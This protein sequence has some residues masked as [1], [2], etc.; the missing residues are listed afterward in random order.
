MPKKDYLVQLIRSLNAAER[1]HF[2]SSV[3]DSRSDRQYLK[4]FHMLEGEQNYDAKTLCKK[5]N[6]QPKQLADDKYYLD[7]MLLKSLRSFDDPDWKHTRL[8]KDLQDAKILADHGMHDDALVAVDK[9]IKEA[10]YLEHYGFVL[11]A[12][13]L[14]RVCLWALLRYD[15]VKATEAERRQ[16]VAAYEEASDLWELSSANYSMINAGGKNAELKEMLKHPVLK[17]KAEGL[18]SIQAKSH[19]YD[20]HKRTY[21]QLNDMQNLRKT[22]DAFREFLTLHPA[23]RDIHAS[24][25]ISMRIN[26]AVQDCMHANY[27]RALSM[28]VQLETDLRTPLRYLDQSST[29]RAQYHMTHL[30]C[31][32]A[33]KTGKYEEACVW[34]ERTY[35]TKYEMPAQERFDVLWEWAIPLV[36]AGRSKEGYE[37]LDALAATKDIRAD[38]QPYIRPL[39][40]IAQI[41]M[42]HYDVAI[43]LIKSSKLWMKRKKIALPELELFFSHAYAIANAPALS[44]KD[45]MLKLQQAVKAGKLAVTDSQIDVGYW[46]E[47]S[48]SLAPAGFKKKP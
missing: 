28:L 42:G 36:H 13:S 2:L 41:D 44:R 19:W 17:K 6:I 22:E 16:I 3:G 29:L 20:I 26:S 45:A 32:I 25:Y 11:Y 38:L 10:T 46:V 15:E 40:V 47:R 30:R 21:A 7:K 14:K 5:L 37:K 39:M 43:Y 35:L 12:Y 27:E 31:Y 24:G 33:R 34:G 8:L 18:K 23:M 4:L 9:I 1:K 48:L